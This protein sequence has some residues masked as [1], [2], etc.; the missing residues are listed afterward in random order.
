MTDE[1]GRFTHPQQKQQ[2]GRQGREEFQ[3]ETK[4]VLVADDGR[5]FGMDR[6]IEFQLQK[7]AGIQQDTGIKKHAAF[8]QLSA[9]TLHNRAREPFSR[10][11]FYRKVDFDP[12]PAARLGVGFHFGRSSLSPPDPANYQGVTCYFRPTKHLGTQNQGRVLSCKLGE[13]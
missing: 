6:R 10:D 5:H 12:G 2:S 8:A 7:V 3:S 13:G 11:D 4:S 1:T 9:A